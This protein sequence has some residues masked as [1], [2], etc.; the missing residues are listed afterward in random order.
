[1]T[2]LLLSERLIEYSRAYQ[3]AEDIYRLTANEKL[4]E[5]LLAPKIELVREMTKDLQELYDMSKKLTPEFQFPDPVKKLAE[6]FRKH[7][8]N[9]PQ[10]V[11]NQTLSILC[12]LFETFL[13]N[14]LAAIFEKK[15][16][17]IITLSEQKEI[18]L[19]DIIELGDYDRIIEIF[20]AKTLRSF[21]RASTIDQFEKYFKK[22]SFSIDA[23][24]DFSNRPL[25]IRTTYTGWGLK[26]LG[27]IFDGRHEIVHNGG[28][29]LANLTDLHIRKVFFDHI[30]VNISR[31]IKEKFDVD[32]DMGFLTRP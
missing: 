12:S 2:E 5:L 10:I 7:I 1:M 26:R 22:L 25:D 13:I 27:S 31:A 16:E 19:R 8:D 29:P 4:K 20:K 14:C 24:F 9:Y 17:T 6:E 30:T 18:Q 32:T 11:I 21:S 23:L 28:K 15:P 3:F